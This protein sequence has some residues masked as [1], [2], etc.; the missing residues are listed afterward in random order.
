M[1]RKGREGAPKRHLHAFLAHHPLRHEDEGGEASVGFGRVE[2]KVALT[3]RVKELAACV[4]L[5]IVFRMAA[6]NALA[7]ALEPSCSSSP[8][9]GC[10]VDAGH[11]SLRDPIAQ[12]V[13]RVHPA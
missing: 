2:V 11:D 3:H 10:F 1:E 5:N 7:L 13:Q 4:L 8:V 9:E 12:H 6:H